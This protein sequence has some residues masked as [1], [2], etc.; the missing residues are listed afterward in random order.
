VT[1]VCRTEGLVAGHGGVP[2]VHGV[3]LEV[4]QGE[5]VA[6]VGPNGAGKSTILFTV[7]GILP[8]LGGR[9]EVLDE[10]VD[11]HGAHVVARR[12]FSLVPEDRGLFYQLSVAD[13]LRLRCGRRGGGEVDGVLDHFP[14]LR[15]LTGRRAGLLS[16]GEQQMLALAGALVGAPRLLVVDEMS[17]GLSPLIV[18]RLLP[19]VRTIA[20]ERSMAVL[21][22][23]QHVG[24]ALGVAD[25][26]YVLSGG[27]IAMEGDA[28][29]LARDRHVLEASYLGDA[30]AS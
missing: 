25:R 12:G 14:A 23:E 1:V 24:M 7:A 3:D 11:G 5:V 9:I 16:G 8:A 4:R 15:P 6:L 21:L 22:V 17:L 20:D 27:R 2:A 18:E 30:A 13:N 10:V 28:A 29:E 19:L 26:G